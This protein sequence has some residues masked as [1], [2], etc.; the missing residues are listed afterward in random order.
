[1]DSSTTRD[2]PRPEDLVLTWD[3]HF[4][5]ISVHSG[6]AQMRAADLFIAIEQASP[7]AARAEVDLWSTRDGVT[8]TRE[9]SVPKRARGAAAGTTRR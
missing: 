2:Q 8:F 4:W 5:N 9:R 6:P 7:L 3:G 1:M